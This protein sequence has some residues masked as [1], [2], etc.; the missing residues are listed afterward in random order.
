MQFVSV[1]DAQR[2][3]GGCLIKY[4]GR[5]FY[6]R[7]VTISPEGGYE[8]TGY[9]LGTGKKVVTKNITKEIIEP[10]KFKM[11]YTNIFQDNLPNPVFI[12]RTPRRV[13]QMG[14]SM[15]NTRV[16]PLNVNGLLPTWEQ[17]VLNQPFLNLQNSVFPKLSEIKD[18]QSL[19]FSE[20][21]AVEK[22]SLFVARLYHNRAVVGEVSLRDNLIY[23]YAPYTYL[24]EWLQTYIASKGENF[25]VQAA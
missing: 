17:V 5:P 16:S 23:L 18:Y 11:G 25:N 14:L 20:E 3:L 8:M 15:D 24:K 12:S 21:F 19:A 9:F 7:H 1:M 4:E 6:S 22:V 10:P 13:T 2:R